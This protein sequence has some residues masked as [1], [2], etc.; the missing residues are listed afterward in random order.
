MATMNAPQL[1]L[2]DEHACAAL[3]PKTQQDYAENTRNHRRK[4]LNRAYDYA[5]SI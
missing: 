5:Q 2:L 4:E 1:L 3:D